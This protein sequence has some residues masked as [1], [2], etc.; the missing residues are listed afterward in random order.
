MARSDFSSSDSDSF[1]MVQPVHIVEH[2]R[3]RA[4]SRSRRRSPE[5]LVPP[6]PPAQPIIVGGNLHRSRSTGARPAKDRGRERDYARD[7]DNRIVIDINNEVQEMRNTPQ[8]SR[9][10]AR[11]PR[12]M[13][14]PE[15]FDDDEWDDP[16]FAVP[17]HAMFRPRRAREA[18]PFHHDHEMHTQIERLKRFEM[19]EDKRRQLEEIRNNERIRK[20]ELEADRYDLEQQMELEHMKRHMEDEDSRKQMEK[21]NRMQRLRQLERQERE[22]AERRELE[23]AQ[24][25]KKLKKMEEEEIAKE[26]FERKLRLEKAEE[27]E[28]KEALKEQEER[29]KKKILLEQAQK[30]AEEAERKKREKKLRKEAVEEYT[31][32]QAEK[33]IKEERE[34]AE[35]DRIFEE[36]VKREFGAAGYSDRH[37]DSILRRRGG[38]EMLMIDDGRCESPPHVHPHAHHHG[39]PALPP[40]PPRPIPYIKVRPHPFLCFVFS[41]LILVIFP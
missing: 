37:I 2:S 26:E 32:E 30:D 11:P 7:R 41:V 5:F 17:H 29:I 33:K 8:R 9:S 15:E 24:K 18:S 34:K 1:D 23:S 27:L 28:K 22:D 31:R 19:E 13:P 12:V 10:Q 21:A 40:P 38:G 35:A 14:V 20:M 3:R 16:R 6:A 4:R 25:L 39:H 36:R